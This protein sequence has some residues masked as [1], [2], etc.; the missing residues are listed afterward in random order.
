MQLRPYQLNAVNATEADWKAGEQSCLVYSPTGTGKTV[1]FIE[2]AGRATGLNERVMIIV[3]RDELV[4]QTVQRIV[5]TL[6]IYPDIEQGDMWAT[7]NS[8]TRSPIIVATIQSLRSRGKSDIPRYQRFDPRTFHRI[9]VDEAHLTITSSFTEVLNHF[10]EG[11]PDIRI[12]G[13]TATPKRADGRSLAQLYPKCS[14]EYP[15]IDAIN[16]GYL[17]PV[18]GKVITVS[19]VSLKGLKVN[20]KTKDFTDRQVGELMEQEKAIFETVG[21]LLRETVGKQTIVFTPRV[22]HAKLMAAAINQELPDS[23]RVIHGELNKDRRKR[24]IE[25]FKAGRIQYLCNCAV[26]T[27][28]FDAPNIEVVANCRPTK[29]WALFTQIVG[30]GTRPLPG[31]VDGDKTKDERITAIADSAKPHLTVLSF[32]GR[33]G[34]MNLVGPEDVLAGDMEPPEVLARAKEIIEEQDEEADIMEAVEQARE[35]IEFEQDEAAV[36]N[37]KIDAV[38]YEINDTDWFD[39]NANFTKVLRSQVDLPEQHTVPFLKAAG[40][41]ANEVASWDTEKRQRA[42]KWLQERESKGMCTLKQANL[43]KRLYPN[44]S[45]QERKDITK[46]EA[47][48]LIGQRFKKKEKATA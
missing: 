28:G 4:S 35:Q 34:S 24:I 1:I 17:V 46:R 3:D 23:A 8:H 37:V 27:T 5:S 26:L 38:H 16:D 21:A 33:E 9:L 19:S 44:L 22:N 10:T 41:A 29:S 39:K 25:D 40:Y 7:T 36:A 32:V 42:A 31:V 2:L 20:S 48:Q 30:R 43:L 11:N 47:Q 45:Q 6:G 18:K 13:F 15:M 12:A 14:F